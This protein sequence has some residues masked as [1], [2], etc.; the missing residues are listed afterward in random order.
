LVRKLIRRSS[1]LGVPTRSDE[2]AGLVL[3]PATITIAPVANLPGV[4][5]TVFKA[6]SSG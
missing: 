2:F 3:F 4:Q 6:I 5:G 1:G